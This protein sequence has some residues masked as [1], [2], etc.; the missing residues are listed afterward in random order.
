MSAVVPSDRSGRVQNTKFN[1]L[2]RPCDGL[3]LH[4]DH[5]PNSSVGSAFEPSKCG[6]SHGLYDDEFYDT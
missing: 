2:A 3:L 5:T 6:S 1:S 4:R